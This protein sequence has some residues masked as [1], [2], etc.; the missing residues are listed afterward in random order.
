MEGTVDATRRIEKRISD[1]VW[2][3]LNLLLISIGITYLKNW[4]SSNEF[5]IENLK[6]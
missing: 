6:Y 2:K 4:T 5:V 3:N 1:V